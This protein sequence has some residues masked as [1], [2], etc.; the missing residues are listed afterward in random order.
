[1]RTQKYEGEL[2]EIERWGEDTKKEK[3]R[4]SEEQ[5]DR[6]RK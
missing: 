5:K 4:H 6:G 2:R 3:K 1:M